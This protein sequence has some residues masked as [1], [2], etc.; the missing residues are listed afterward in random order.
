MFRNSDFQ[1]FIQ[2]NQIRYQTDGVAT[3]WIEQGPYWALVI[4]NERHPGRDIHLAE[5]F[6][7]SPEK[8]FNFIRWLDHLQRQQT[9][10]KYL[11]VHAR[12]KLFIKYSKYTLRIATKRLDGNWKCGVPVDASI[13]LLSQRLWFEHILDLP[14]GKALNFLWDIDHA[15]QMKSM[16]S[17]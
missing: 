1:P 13:D 15:A 12:R 8:Q 2:S 14:S 6:W 7:S 9:L 3:D 10:K 17:K 4:Y 5:T 11:P 16:L